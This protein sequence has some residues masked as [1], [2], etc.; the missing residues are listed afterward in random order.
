MRQHCEKNCWHRSPRIVDPD[1]LQHIVWQKEYTPLDFQSDYNAVHGNAFGS[2]SHGLFQSA[3]FRPHNVARDIPGLYFAG[4]G[5][6]PGIGMPMVLIS[7]DLVVQRI[8]SSSI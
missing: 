1:L 6:Y 7:S 8:I 5:T 4:Q 2:L 3:F